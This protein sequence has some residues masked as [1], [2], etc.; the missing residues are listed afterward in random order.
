M[1]DSLLMPCLKTHKQAVHAFG[2][3]QND[4]LAASSSVAIMPFKPGKGCFLKFDCR[5]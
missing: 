3:L 1:P 5:S 2:D 4:A